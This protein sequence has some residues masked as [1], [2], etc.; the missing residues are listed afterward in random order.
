M[1]SH[2]PPPPTDWPGWPPLSLC[3]AITRIER[4][5]GEI[6]GRQQAEAEETRRHLS[7]QDR[8]LTAIEARVIELERR[9]AVQVLDAPPSHRHWTLLALIELRSFLSAVATPREWIV[10]AVIVALALKGVLAPE[11]LRRWLSVVFGRGPT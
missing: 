8:Q 3:E 9:P 10:G 11:E 1:N 6:S 7:L 2:H 4:R 5:L